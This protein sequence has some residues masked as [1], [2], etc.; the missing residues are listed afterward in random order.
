MVQQL[1]PQSKAPCSISVESNALLIDQAYETG[2]RDMEALRAIVSHAS[3]IGCADCWV[4]GE[5]HV[6]SHS[7]NRSYLFNTLLSS[8]RA[9]RREEN[10]FWPSCYRCW[11][12]FQAPC[13]HPGIKKGDQILPE[14]CPY[15]EIP[16]L[17]PTL[18]SLI[19]I[20]D[21]P[22]RSFL[23]RVSATLALNPP[24][25]LS[26]SRFLQWVTEPASSADKVPNFALFLIT[27]SQCFNR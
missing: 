16:H 4:L 27:F 12:P 24:L 23:T 2:K 7:H 17:I 9:K 11:V 22:S 19:Y 1:V 21:D 14:D 5:S 18:C 13:G 20:Y 26:M 10:V 3:A 8:L 25:S 6:G 15:P